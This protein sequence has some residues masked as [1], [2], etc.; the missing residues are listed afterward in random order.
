MSRTIVVIAKGDLGG[1]ASDLGSDAALSEALLRDTITLAEQLDPGSG[2]QLPRLVLIYPTNREWYQRRVSSQWL[3]I[4]QMGS[5]TAQYLDNALIVLG[6][7]P[8][9]QTIFLTT[10]TPHLASRDFLRVWTE[11]ENHEAV[12]GPCENG[13]LYL[14]GIKGR[15]PCGIL[16]DVRWN[17]P[18]ARIGITKAF[19]RARL[20]YKLLPQIYALTELTQLRR[21]ETE[22][23]TYPDR[24]L[25]N[26]RHLIRAA[27]TELPDLPRPEV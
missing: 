9:D 17:T 2:L 18:Q 24:A 4:P 8:N 12:I 19:K 14:I 1:T 26:V 13:D 3:L 6:I 27:E 15:W 11:L 10:C 22:L 25:V 21:L 7:E 23:S 5:D 16:G 20:D